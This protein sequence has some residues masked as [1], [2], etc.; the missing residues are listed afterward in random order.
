ML[1]AP[2]GTRLDGD[3]PRAELLLDP[4]AMKGTEI[5]IRT[6][7]HAPLSETGYASTSLLKENAPGL[8]PRSRSPAPRLA[9]FTPDGRYKLGGDIAGPA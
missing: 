3:V 7:E 1:S 9:A 5:R 2:F 8:T 6:G 4:D